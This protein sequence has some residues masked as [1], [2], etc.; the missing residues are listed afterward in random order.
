MRLQNPVDF[1]PVEAAA[2]ADTQFCTGG[3]C[4]PARCAIHCSQRRTCNVSRSR[5]T[6]TNAALM[7]PATDVA[8]GG[9]ATGALQSALHGP[10]NGRG[11]DQS[12]ALDRPPVTRV[13]DM[14]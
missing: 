13:G 11:A 8:G 5:S 2:S 6:Y 1:K 3:I 12:G 10:G 7:I 9:P 4:S 14:L